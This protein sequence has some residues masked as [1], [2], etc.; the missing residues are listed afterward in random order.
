MKSNWP[1]FLFAIGVR[2]FCGGFLGALAGLLLGYRFVLRR[3]SHNDLRS[4]AWWLGAW[5][6]GGSLLAIFRIPYWQTPWYKGI[7]DTD[8]D[9][10][11]S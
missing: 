5:A 1:D 3:F 8:D 10:D 7:R 9:H 4:V 11:D 6:L 2:F